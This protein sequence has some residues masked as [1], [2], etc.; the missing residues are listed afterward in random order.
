M[1]DYSTPLYW[2]G[3]QFLIERGNLARAIR[4]ADRGATASEFLGAALLD[5]DAAL[6]FGNRPSMD[7]L[8]ELAA[9]LYD[10]ALD[11]LPHDVAEPVEH[12]PRD[13]AMRRTAARRV[14][15]S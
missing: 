6:L 1:P 7:E 9:V 4:R 14:V 10:D 13:W 2:R 3:H 8:S 11:A 15:Q 5:R 12:T